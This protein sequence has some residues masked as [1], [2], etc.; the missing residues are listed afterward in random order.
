MEDLVSRIGAPSLVDL[1]IQ[2][3]DDVISEVTVPQLRQF[4]AL[5]EGLPPFGG[6]FVRTYPSVWFFVL[7]T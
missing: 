3:F 1:R 7:T 2:L 4:I 6:S 5:T